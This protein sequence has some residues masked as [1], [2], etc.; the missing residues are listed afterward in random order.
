VN[1]GMLGLCCEWRLEVNEVLKIPGVGQW[2]N[3][4]NVFKSIWFVN[5]ARFVQTKGRSS[6]GDCNLY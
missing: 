2:D 4:L 1:V 5:D 6:L 3:R